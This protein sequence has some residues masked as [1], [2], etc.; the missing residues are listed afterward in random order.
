MRG[1]I[2]AVLALLL[3]TAAATFGLLGL[4]TAAYASAPGSPAATGS[5]D[6]MSSFTADYVLDAE[7]GATVTET[8]DYVFGTSTGVKHGILRNIVT[9]QAVTDA[10]GRVSEDEYRYYALD[11]QDVTSPTGAPT[12]TK[13]TDQSGGTTQIRVGD[14]DVTVSGSQTYVL[15]YHLANVMNPF[16]DHAEF[17]YNVFLGDSVPKDHVKV[18][19][20]G[21]GG[22]TA[23]TAFAG[24]TQGGPATVPSRARPPLHRG[25]PP[26]QR[27]P[28]H[29]DLAPAGRVRG[30]QARH[31]RGR[32]GLR[33]GQAKVL[34]S[35]ALAG[36]IGAP[37]VAVGV[38]G[39]LVATRGR[40][41]WYA[42]MTRAL[43]GCVGRGRPG[44]G[45]G[46][47]RSRRC[48]VA[49]PRSRCSSTL[50]PASSR[51]W[52]APSSTSRPTPSTSRRR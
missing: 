41:E 18:T 5:F 6:R 36:G 38:M 10:N 37:L 52:S 33:R 27:G 19:V 45:P 35:L 48:A 31:P 30:A 20:T 12:Q 11:V 50:R 1:R 44:G 46:R 21:P 13:V 9:Q 42:G 22:V 7:G 47:H 28:H 14:P 23:S 3:A 15:K 25:Q 26:R 2:P 43:P 16:P 17:F 49:N 39:V 24:P 4:P 32:L 40:D 51:G 29:R 34:T 8:I